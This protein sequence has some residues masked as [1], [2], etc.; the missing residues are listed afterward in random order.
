MENITD[1]QKGKTTA[2]VAYL[3]FVGWL[4]ALFMNK[5]PKS[6]FA[7]FHLRQALG[8]HL[9]YL[10]FVF[11]VSGFDSWWV[12]GAYWLLTFM[13]WLYGFLGALGGKKTLIPL[14]G[15]YFEKWFR[16]LTV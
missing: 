16:G 1:I 9:L 3:T 6:D 11:V 10:L 13:L 7:A 2:I 12:T 8:V 4:I 15:E 14:L 5:E